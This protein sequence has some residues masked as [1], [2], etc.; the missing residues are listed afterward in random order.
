MATIIILNLL[1][2]TT[3][4]LPI[5]EAVQ[6]LAKEMPKRSTFAP[7]AENR[8]RDHQPWR[9][10]CALIQVRSHTCATSVP[11]LLLKLLIWPHTEEPIRER[12]PFDVLFASVVSP[13]VPLWP[14]ICA[15]IQASGRIVAVSARKLSVTA[16]LWQN[17][18]VSIREKSLINAICACC[19]LASPEIS[20]V[21]WKSI[22]P[23]DTSRLD[24]SP[25]NCTVK[26]TRTQ[27]CG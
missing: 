2:I 8:M 7:S 15:L 24:I 3:E 5:M 10:T 25:L 14:R 13:K 9:H 16:L 18:S 20:T 23:N 17:T 27:F 4:C 6:G 19:D 26:Y 1:C 22:W 11:R 12:S 21:T